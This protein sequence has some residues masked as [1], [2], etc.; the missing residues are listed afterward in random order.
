MKYFNRKEDGTTYYYIKGVLFG[1][2]TNADGT[3]DI[4]D[5]MECEVGDYLEPLTKEEIQAIEKELA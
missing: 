4:D 5:D 2:P 1:H 3:C